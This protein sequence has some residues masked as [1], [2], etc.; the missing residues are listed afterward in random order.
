MK[1]V[2][3]TLDKAYKVAKVDDRLFGSF[4]EHLGRA[5]YGGIYQPGHPTADKY[6]YRQDV[7]QLVRELQV[8]LIRYP[9][10][11]FVSNF[12]WEDSV[13]PVDKRPARLDLAWRSLEPNTFGLEEFYHWTKQVN[14]QIMMAVNLGTRGVADACNLLEYCNHP[15]GSKYS[16][17]RRSHGV[18]N[19]YNIKLWC[20]GNEM[21][22]SWQ[23]GSKTMDEYGRISQ[24]AGKAMKL[25]DPSIELVSC[26]SSYREMPVPKGTMITAD[27]ITQKEV[28]KS[29]IPSGA[30]SNPENLTELISVYAVDQ[31]SIITTGMFTAVNDITKDMTQPVVA[32]F[33]ADDLYQ[34]VGGVLR[35]GDRINIYQVNENANK[36]DT[37]QSL[38]NTDDNWTDASSDTA[39]SL[40][41]GN[42]FVQEVFDSAGAVI[43]T[44]DST[45][46]AQRV[47]IYM[48]NDNVAAFYAALAQGSL[49]VVKICE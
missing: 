31:G 11:N 22:G 14:A 8:P 28:D 5:V 47:N 49:R 4:I 17:L 32:G 7:V 37:S 34:V 18:E 10:G 45:T 6:G 36:G 40:V 21:D 44:S 23:L 26:G 24:E 38:A 9:G 25:I 13:G 2:K 27:Y 15:G 33:K 12:F 35:S 20:L 48:D 1:Q 46:P 16:D 29:L 30:V 42:V 19:P 41:W 43:S 3:I 39:A